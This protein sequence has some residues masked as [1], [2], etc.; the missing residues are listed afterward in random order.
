MRIHWQMLITIWLRDGQYESGSGQSSLG[1]LESYSVPPDLYTMTVVT[2]S[3]ISKD[4]VRHPTPYVNVPSY[5]V[6]GKKLGSRSFEL[7]FPKD[8]QE[9]I[10]AVT[11]R[12][13]LNPDAARKL[14]FDPD[15]LKPFGG[16]KTVVVRSVSG[17]KVRL[18]TAGLEKTSVE[19]AIGEFP[20]FRTVT[21]TEGWHHEEGDLN[22]VDYEQ[23]TVTRL[24]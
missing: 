15:T 8:S 2:G 16:G 19:R 9:P 20:L 11:Y 14:G 18:E 21:L 4:L 10:Y 17:R 3:Y 7:T 1:D 12:C 23:I 5:S 22:S 24:R 13:T 6:P